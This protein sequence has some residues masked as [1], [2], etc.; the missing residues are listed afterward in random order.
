MEVGMINKTPY[1]FYIRAIFYSLERIGGRNLAEIALNSSQQSLLVLLHGSDKEDMSLSEIEK[2]MNL[3]QTGVA[4][5]TTQL[6][7]GGWINKYT[8]ES[9]KRVKK[10]TLSDK[11]RK[12]CEASEGDV[13]ATES[14]LLDG[15]SNEEQ[16]MF[17][18]CLSIIYENSLR[19]E[20][21]GIQNLQ[22]A[23]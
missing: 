3:S 14:N 1:S 20:N 6:Y 2:E 16:K 13:L 4:K 7:N 8:D 9:D 17:Q 23:E 19:L 21:E 5:L 18:K 22:K 11:G 15:M 10:V 12:Y